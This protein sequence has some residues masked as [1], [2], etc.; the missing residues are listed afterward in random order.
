MLLAVTGR[1]AA[2]KTTIVEWFVEQGWEGCSCSD[3]IRHWLKENGKEINRENLTQGGRSLRSKGGP[4]ILAE[5]LL[6]R[7]SPEQPTI[8]DS[9]RT[10]DEV[11]ALREREGFLLIEVHAPIDLRWERMQ[12]RGREGDPENYQDFLSQEEAEAVA[13]NSSGQAL[14]ATAELADLLIINDGTRQELD[15]SLKILLTTIESRL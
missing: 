8:I 7:I 5:L 15:E 3:S 9:I 14:V 4:G 2:G 10:P 12:Q 1:N 13:K 6:E 11:H